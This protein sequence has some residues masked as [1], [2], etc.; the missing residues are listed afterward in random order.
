MGSFFMGGSLSLLEP[1]SLFAALA[2][3][4]V[5]LFLAGTVGCASDQTLR[6]KPSV[7]EK[8]WPMLHHDSAHTGRSPRD[9]PE[10]PRQKWRV[11]ILGMSS[12]PSIGSDGTVYVTTDDALHGVGPSGKMRWVRRLVAR[13]Y[14][15]V[16]Y[17]PGSPVV[18]ASGTI[19][20][21]GMRRKD[22]TV[23]EQELTD[24]AA[25]IPEIGDAGLDQREFLKAVL[26]DM[27]HRLVAVGA[28]TPKGELKWTSRVHDAAF[29]SPTIA[30]DGTI[31]VSGA[32][33]TLY[34]LNGDGTTRWIF[35]S[36]HPRLPEEF[37]GVFSA[38]AV[39]PDGTVYIGGLDGYLHA[40]R[41]DGTKRWDFFTKDRVM[42][43]PVVGRDGTLFAG[44]E[45][46]V[47][48]ALSPGGA[49]RWSFDTKSTGVSTLA[50]GPDG[51]VY[52][53][54]DAGTLHALAPD[55]K[56]RWDLRLRSSAGLTDAVVARNGVYCGT[57]D[58]H[59]LALT[60]SGKQRWSYR[61]GADQTWVVIG[62]DGTLYCS[63]LDGSLVAI[64][65]R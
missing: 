50:L 65:N 3:V 38:P 7:D 18:T 22:E 1:R 57:D 46:G 20:A 4:S 56:E 26:R 49:R 54:S 51:T 60:L 62:G 32:Y 53:A 11:K 17:P 30:P 29:S 10:R 25:S 43:S 23:T 34:A 48:Y 58:G 41:P 61:V 27:Q 52:G 24:L 44:A 63:T 59:L 5:A 9:G 37:L 13:A 55:G 15:E 19:Y 47:L 2:T 8:A 16:G 28:V 21:G 39:G 6:Q 36:R 33:R 12:P 40:V 42:T 31:Y 45:N 35:R 14:N 64:G